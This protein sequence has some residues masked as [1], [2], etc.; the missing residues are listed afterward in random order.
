MAGILASGSAYSQL[1][2]APFPVGTFEEGTFPEGTF[3]EGAFEEGIR[4]E[5]FSVENCPW[6]STGAFERPAQWTALLSSPVTVAGPLRLHRIPT[7]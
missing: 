3:E 2:L 5:A 4:P 7:P 6:N 1:L